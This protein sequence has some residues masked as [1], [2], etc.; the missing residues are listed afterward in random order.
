MVLHPA[1][2]DDPVEFYNSHDEMAREVETALC[3]HGRTVD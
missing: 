2:H 3:E 1:C